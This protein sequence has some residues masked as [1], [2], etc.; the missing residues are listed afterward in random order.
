MDLSDLYN[1]SVQF[2]QL[3]K[4][5]KGS[6]AGYVKLSGLSGSSA[7]AFAASFFKQ[8]TNNHLFILNDKESAANMA[9]DLM[10]LLGE[11]RILFFPSSHKR[12]VQYHQPDPSGVI[13]RTEALSKLV[14]SNEAYILVSYPEA[15]VEKVVSKD[16]LSR[17]TLQLKAGESISISFVKEV[18]SEYG[19]SRQD[20]VYEPGQFAIRGSIVDVFSYS[21][22]KPY[23]ID[24]FGD[25]VESI[26]TF[27]LETQL[28]EQ[29]LKSITVIP[30]L[31]SINVKESRIDLLSFL[32][33]DSHIW[34]EDIG[35]TL[36]RIASVFDNTTLVADED[37]NLPSLTKAE[38]LC[39]REE[40]ENQLIR[41]II[42]DRSSL[43]WIKPNLVLE[44]NT[45]PQPTFNKKFELIAESLNEYSAQNYQSFILSDNPKQ[46]E[47]IRQIFND[48]KLKVDYQPL[49]F[50]IHE[51]FIDHD[52]KICLYTDHQIFERYH[53]YKLSQQFTRNETLTLSELFNLHPGDYV[54]HVDHGIGKFGGLVKVDQNGKQQ[55]V[56]RLVYQDNDVLYV[57]IHSLHKISKFKGKDGSEPKIYKLGSGAWQR[58]KA[59]TKSKVKDIA[60]ELI[61]L[62]A[63]RK[64]MPGFRFSPDSYLQQ[65]L[66]ASFI[67]EDTPDQE[68]ATRMVK[69]AL[70]NE[71]P[72]DMLVCGDVGFGKTEIA[73]R[74]AFKAVADNKQ[75]AVLV[76]TTILALQHYKTFSER[77]KDFPC[78]VDYVSRLKS[79]KQIKETLKNTVDGKVDILIGTHRI[80]GKDVKFKDLGLLIIDEE[81]KFGVAVKEKLRQLKLNVDTLTL[82]ATPIPRTLQFSLMGARDLAIMSTPPP[83][84]HPIHTEL[85]TL[86]EDIIREAIEYE[87]SRGGQVF[88]INNRIQNIYEVDALLHRIC[89]NINTLVAHGQMDG[90]MLEKIMLDFINGDADVLIAT[91][92]IES[93]LDISNANTI[94]INDAQNFGLSDLHQLRGRVGRSNKRA[95]CYLLAPPLSTLTPEA[96]RRLKA[97]EDFSDLGSGF[98]IAMQDLDIRGA[99]NL[100]GGEQSGF[101]TDIGFETYHKILNEALDELKETEFS[102]LFAEEQKVAESKG[103]QTVYVSDVVIDTDLELLFPDAYIGNITER[104]KLYRELDNLTDEQGL[105]TFK[106]QLVDRF[107]AIPPETLDLLEVVRL[108]WLAQRLGMEKIILKGGKM[109]V[110]FISNQDSKFYKTALFVRLIQTIQKHSRKFAIKESRDKLTLTVD[111]ILSVTK[112]IETL[113]LLER[114]SQAN[115]NEPLK[116]NG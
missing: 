30:N 87:V 67:Y 40:F 85:H 66:E 44:F 102:E 77:L 80:I 42:L 20:F 9:N 114:E 53:K 110:N 10:Q 3:E 59:T 24:F 84:R 38:L 105:E 99:G 95:F 75:V 58:L 106:N 18:L 2:E 8:K 35:F 113:S 28:S 109:L 7:A 33:P 83:N 46:Q 97:L 22:E 73:I 98:N 72:M 41:R 5:T 100:L 111:N 45:S 26:R 23:R 92:I 62:Y 31:Q 68:K 17:N 52:L 108:R 88:F 79:P 63:K 37:G 90:P 96:R 60:R 55:E 103:I 104:M 71:H 6:A 15:L 13:S 65:Q 25:E 51:G 116:A 101:I 14:N 81:Q 19:F 39:S 36:D 34:S 82:T 16:N 50:I 70:E 74:A 11:K 27:D 69:E 47:R 64:N 89:P 21:S 12:S 49:D 48:M 91:S 115:V 78:Q 76:P 57:S 1:N 43:G 29:K 56:I 112:A 61:A 4:Y 86:N 93:G 32:K 107:G 54:V 94:I